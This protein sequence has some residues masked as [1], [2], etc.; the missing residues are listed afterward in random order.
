MFGV[1]IC[2]SS[3]N[4]INVF[5]LLS[6][7]AAANETHPDAKMRKMI[8]KTHAALRLKIR[9]NEDMRQDQVRKVN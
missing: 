9:P 4:E 3:L 8:G 6:M 7:D 2:I 1:E 5:S